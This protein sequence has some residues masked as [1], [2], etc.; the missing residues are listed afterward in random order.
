MKLS[1]S[2]LTLSTPALAAVLNT[3]WDGPLQHV[4]GS[5]PSVHGGAGASD[6]ACDL[7]PPVAPDADGLPSAH[8][9]FGGPEALALQV[10]RHA[11]LVSVP[12][13]SYDAMEDVGKDPRW[14]IFYEFED[15]LK[16]QFPTVFRR[17]ELT[18]VNTHGLVF[19]IQGSK[20]DLKPLMLTAHQDVVPVPDPS[21]WKYPP[22]AAHYD[23][24]WLWGRGAVD[25]K[26]SLTGILSVV[27]TL[28][29][30]ATWTPRRSILLAFGFDEESSG[31]YGAG[32]IAKYLEDTYGRESMVLLLDEGGSGIDSVKGE[33]GKEVVYA[34]PA[35]M[36]KGHVDILYELHVRGGH[37]SMP[38]PHTGIG[39]AAEI[40]ATLENNPYTPKLVDGSPLHQL[41]VCR[42]RYTPEQDPQS[43]KLVREGDLDALAQLLSSYSPAM[44]FQLRTSQAVDI[45]NAGLKINAMPEKIEIGVNY[46]V[47][48]HNS[49]AEVK[50]RSIALLQPILDKYQITL[51]AFGKD[52]VLPNPVLQNDNGVRAAY[53]VDYNATLILQSRQETEVARV[54]PTSGGVWDLFSG[55]IQHTFAVPDGQVVPVGSIMNGNTDTRHYMNLTS[56]VYRWVPVRHD[57][58]LHMHAIDE[59]LNMEAHMETVRFYYNLIRNFDQS[60]L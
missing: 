16:K 40:I 10:R 34:V 46:R 42:A 25:D 11:A 7:P 1:T 44:D 19:F 58:V 60:D 55:T 12:S 29:Q 21:A 14:D 33:D 17:A 2:L 15:T 4:I 6:F 18:H 5:R 41:S 50:E 35:V 38:L 59:G 47:A 28:L 3:P 23:G 57:W 43:T 26:N 51:K 31:K 27:E 56:R 49:L 13:V 39:I 24:S 53:A 9:L 32:S 48:P 54:S 45:I 8:D 36:E 37:S 20:T 22:F 52:A 30:N